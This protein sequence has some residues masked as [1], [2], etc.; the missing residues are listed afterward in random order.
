VIQ[1]LQKLAERM[2]VRILKV[3]INLMAHFMVIMV[4]VQNYKN[5]TRTLVA[6]HGIQKLH[7]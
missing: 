1:H 6:L 2:K 4:H 7:P 5:F 3:N